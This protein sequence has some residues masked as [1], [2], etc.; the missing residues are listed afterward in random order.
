MRI[1]TFLLLSV[2]GLTQTLSAMSIGRDGKPYEIEH[3]MWQPI[4]YTDTDS[5]F[6]A[7]LPGAPTSGLMNDCIYS[8]S[9]YQGD[10]FQISVERES[11]ETPTDKAEDFLNLII[12]VNPDGS[13]FRLIPSMQEGV[14]HIVEGIFED[15]QITRFYCGHNKI[16][17][18]LF[19]GE[20]LLLADI[21]FNSMKITK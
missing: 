21:F 6:T 13:N 1:F 8:Y 19:Q 11:Y 4:R 3:T 16:Y 17:Q 20:N 12:D 10:Y 14:F 2:M 5:G 18:M 9:Q 7:L 15:N